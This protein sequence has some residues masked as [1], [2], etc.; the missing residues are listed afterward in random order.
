MHSLVQG[1]TQ[2]SL[3]GDAPRTL[4]QKESFFW[5]VNSVILVI[6]DP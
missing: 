1:P 2:T 4:E 5:A 3:G 6:P